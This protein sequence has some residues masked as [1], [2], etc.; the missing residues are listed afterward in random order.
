MNLHVFVYFSM[1]LRR[2]ACAS[3]VS[4][5]ASSRKIILNPPSPMGAILAKSLIFVRTTS[6]PLSSEAFSSLKLR[7]QL[8]PKSSRVSAIA[9]VVL[10]VPAGP[11]KRRWGRFLVFTYALSLSTISS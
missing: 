5:S 3:D 1:V 6:M 9:H 7:L 10:P 2:A 11:A 4:A 8:S